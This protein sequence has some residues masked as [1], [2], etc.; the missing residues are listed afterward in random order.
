MPKRPGK[1]AKFPRVR[2]Y[3]PVGEHK[4]LFGVPGAASAR[5]RRQYVVCESLYGRAGAG[6]RDRSRSDLGDRA[7]GIL[8]SSAPCRCPERAV[9]P[10]IACNSQRIDLGSPPDIE[11]AAP[12]G[13]DTPLRSRRRSARRH[14]RC[15]THHQWDPAAGKRASVEVAIPAD[16]RREQV[17]SAARATRRPR[18]SS[19]GVRRDAEG[20]P[21]WGTRSGG[22][23]RAACL[24]RASDLLEAGRAEFHELLV[25]EAGK[26][27][28]DAIAEVREAVDFCRYYAVQARQ[29]FR[30]LP[31]RCVTRPTGESNE[32][33]LHGRGVFA[34]I[35]PWNFPLAIFA[36]QV[37]HGCASRPAIPSWRSR[38]NYDPAD[39][40]TLRE[41]AARSRHS[42]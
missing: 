37:R 41:A 9:L 38:R 24:D 32:L 1:I 4:D 27:I 17:R 42:S 39:R 22:D 28:S 29:Q 14:G 35:S 20:Q 21:A 5:E 23:A 36:G 40:R 18:R 25:R 33:S 12:G 11:V 26:T 6:C 34:C 15:R 30:S 8:C 19:D 31:K 3:A 13:V 7:F 2:V 10:R 16:H